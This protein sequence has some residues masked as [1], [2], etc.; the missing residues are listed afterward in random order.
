MEFIKCACKI[1]ERQE[2]LQND[3]V[4]SKREETKELIKTKYENADINIFNSTQKVNL[5]TIISYKKDGKI[6]NF[7]DEY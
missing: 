6:T 4:S 1:T 7:L 5:D 2:K 3:E